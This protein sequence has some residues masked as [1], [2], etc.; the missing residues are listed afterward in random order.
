[1]RSLWCSV[2]PSSARSGGAILDTTSVGRI[3]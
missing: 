1:V 2:A 3:S